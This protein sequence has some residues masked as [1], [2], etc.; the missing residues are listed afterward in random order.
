MAIQ[1][2]N[3]WNERK[4]ESWIKN[5]IMHEI[6][7]KN[8][9]HCATTPVHLGWWV[10]PKESQ[11]PLCW[12]DQ[13]FSLNIF[14]QCN[15][16]PD[17]KHMLLFKVIYFFF[18]WVD[19]VCFSHII[20]CTSFQSGEGLNTNG[21]LLLVVRLDWPKVPTIFF[22]S[23]NKLLLLKRPLEIQFRFCWSGCC[24]FFSLSLRLGSR[25]IKQVSCFID[26]FNCNNF[27]IALVNRM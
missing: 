1:P 26:I 24:R 14:G 9:P 16:G 11:W 17:F 15:R 18:S 5:Q 7:K 6:L 19:P 4:R 25:R 23:N 10:V 3:S 2:T 20:F 13:I 8:C 21:I 12:E 27:L 22:Q